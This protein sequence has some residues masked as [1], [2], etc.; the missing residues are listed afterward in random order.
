MK[1]IGSLSSPPLSSKFLPSCFK[2]WA[3]TQ[4]NIYKR[5]QCNTIRK[6]LQIVQI[7]QKNAGILNKISKFSNKMNVVVGRGVRRERI[8]SQFF[9]F[10]RFLLLLLLYPVSVTADIPIASVS[11]PFIM[12]PIAHHPKALFIFIFF[13]GDQGPAVAN[14][15]FCKKQVTKR[16]LSFSSC[17]YVLIWPQR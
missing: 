12:L 16:A 10:D 13:M 11:R 3:M 1:V 7:I 2:F 6:L 15:R 8:K 17:V 5:F 9:A 14:R 4:L